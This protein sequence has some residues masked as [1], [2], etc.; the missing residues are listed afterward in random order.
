[1]PLEGLTPAGQL[2]PKNQLAEAQNLGAFEMKVE[3]NEMIKRTSDED[4]AN[5]H[6]GSGAGDEENQEQAFVEEL[7][8]TAEQMLSQKTEKIL[9]I[10]IQYT[11]SFNKYTELVELIDLKNG[12]VLQ[13]VPP[14]V[15]IG[16][17]SDLKYSS[18][19]FVDNEI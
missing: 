13:A 17:V 7:S 4:G 12:D 18:G 19:L 8:E 2:I 14:G 10:N 11:L 16:M 1:M 9:D 15:L 6:A 3:T 5:K